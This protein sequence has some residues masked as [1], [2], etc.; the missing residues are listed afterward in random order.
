MSKGSARQIP[1]ALADFGENQFQETGP[2]AVEVLRVKAAT[3]RKYWSRLQGISYLV[4]VISSDR[5]R[6]YFFNSSAVMLV[7]ENID[8]AQYLKVRG[9]SKLIK[10][11]ERPRPPTE[12]E[13]RMEATEELRSTL[14]KALRRVSRFLGEKEPEFPDIY[15]S[16]TLDFDSFQSF[17]L[18]IEDDGT[19]LFLES[20]TASSQLEALSLRSAFLSLLDPNRARSEFS[21]SIANTITA[22]LLKGESRERWIK[23]WRD[24]ANDTEYQGLVNHL[25]LHQECYGATG[26]SRFLKLIRNAPPF[27]TVERWESATKVLHDNHE[28]P[29]G[30]EAWPIISGFCKTLE[31]PRNLSKN[32]YTFDA[33]HLAARVI[34]NPV[35]L[36]YTLKLDLQ[37]SSPLSSASWLEVRF[38]DGAH[39]RKLVVS[40][41]SGTPV[42]SI[43]Y[44]LRIADIFPKQGGIMSNGKDILRWA[45]QKLTGLIDDSPTFDISVS[46]KEAALS[47]SEKAVLERL[48]LGNSSILS[49]TL[50]GSPQ[51]IESLIDSGCIALVP[52][53]GHMGIEPILL[54]SGKMNVIRES[55]LPNVLEA[56]TLETGN[57]SFAIISAPSVWNHHLIDIVRDLD[58]NLHLLDLIHSPR[59]LIRVEELF[60]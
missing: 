41:D 2:D 16:K 47:E 53:F 12:L 13:L 60:E 15:V 52:S 54:V 32:R 10:K 27:C 38:L 1:K 49:N 57:M 43:S 5:V 39:H 45:L 8:H 42:E 56:T 30:T 18:K 50:V 34:C 33:I 28:V 6:V 3:I 22:M 14:S 9:K 31:K 46:M 20:S 17:G 21:Q 59:K 7:G 44:H 51:R 36:G 23:Q 37:D 48:S 4:A 25:L 26:G 19:F 24:A 29:L 35:P 58:L 11:Y 40:A 55:I